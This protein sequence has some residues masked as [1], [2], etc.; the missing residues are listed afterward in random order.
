VRTRPTGRCRQCRSMGGAPAA[1]RSH[2]RPF[3]AT[4]RPTRHARFSLGSG[5]HHDGLARQPPAENGAPGPAK[6]PRDRVRLH[7]LAGRRARRG[8]RRNPDERHRVRRDGPQARV[9]QAP[10]VIDDPL[11]FTELHLSFE[12]PNDR[13]LEGTFSIVLPQGAAISRFAMKNERG[14]QEGEVVEKQQAR[15]A[16]EDFLHRRQDPALLEQAAGNEFSARVF[17]IQARSKKELIV[18]Y[19]QELTKRSPYVLPLKGLP[20]I[21]SV[22]VQA[23]VAG[24]AAPVL[25]L[26]KQGLKPEGDFRVDPGALGE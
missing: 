14:F 19:S 16:Y 23:Y 25:S 11:A 3:H 18:S 1:P 9:A 20:E 13:V 4:V 12:N 15:V 21:G 10:A 22:D 17:P 7:P 5:L 2:R 26:S 24:R 6:G 8:R